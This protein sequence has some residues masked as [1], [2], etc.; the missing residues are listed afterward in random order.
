LKIVS[1]FRDTGS[2][3]HERITSPARWKSRDDGPN[4]FLDECKVERGVDILI[5]YHVVL[6]ARLKL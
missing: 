3:E 2:A 1:G 5:D 4:R 6:V